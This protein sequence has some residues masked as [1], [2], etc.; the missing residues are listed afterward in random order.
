M[1]DQGYT[2]DIQELARLL[3]KQWAVILAC[4]IAMRMVGFVFGVSHGNYTASQP[5][6]ISAEKNASTTIQKVQGNLNLLMEN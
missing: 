3:V 4:T 2:I 5:L 6:A 1:S